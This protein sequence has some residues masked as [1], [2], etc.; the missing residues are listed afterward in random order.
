MK[1]LNALFMSALL[2]SITNNSYTMEDKINIIEQTSNVQ[3]DI[4]KQNSIN[5]ISALIFDSTCSKE[6]I[7]SFIEKACAD[8]YEIQL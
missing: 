3:N 2:L 8:E 7:N 1:K 4:L 6:K 5:K